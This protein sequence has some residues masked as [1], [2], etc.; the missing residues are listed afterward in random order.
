MYAARRR[1]ILGTCASI[2]AACLAVGG[3]VPEN[4]RRQ[5]GE[6]LSVSLDT[7]SDIPADPYLAPDA[8]LFL[9]G[10]ATALTTPAFHDYLA[11]MKAQGQGFHRVSKVYVTPRGFGWLSTIERTSSRQQGDP[12]SF[13][14]ALWL[15]GAVQN[16]R[17]TRLWLH[18]T[19]EALASTRQQPEAYRA[20][21]AARGLPVPNGWEQGTPALLAAAELE[22]RQQTVADELSPSPLLETAIASLGVSSL[23]VLI[24]CRVRR[25]NMQKRDNAGL[26]QDG[27]LLLS[28]RTWSAPRMRRPDP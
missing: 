7:H 10:A 25:P 13:T 6:R 22:D 24:A 26:G 5:L 15:E 14:A 3:C 21:A 12:Q 23:A 19:I 4:S 11:R 27:K 18:F 2:A 20:A 9:Q 8:E 1:Q 16:D 17:I 28:L